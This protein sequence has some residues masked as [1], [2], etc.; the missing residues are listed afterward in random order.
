MPAKK[1]KN[2]EATFLKLNIAGHIIEI[3]SD[4]TV[5][6]IEK[7]IFFALQSNQIL[8]DMEKEYETPNTQLSAENSELVKQNKINIYNIEVQT[9]LLNHIKNKIW[10]ETYNIFKEEVLKSDEFKK[11]KSRNWL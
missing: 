3:N 2:P 1:I 9:M 7:H 10:F 6:E 5:E 8:I 11:L 4:M